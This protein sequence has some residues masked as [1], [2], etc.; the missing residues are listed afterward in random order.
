MHGMEPRPPG[1]RLAQLPNVVLT[2]HLAGGSKL[3]LLQEL[4]ALFQNCRA[5]LDGRPIEHAVVQGLNAADREE[6]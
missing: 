3:A 1:D 4:E 5:A 2:P 6:R